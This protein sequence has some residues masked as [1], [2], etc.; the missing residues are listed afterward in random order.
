MS[1]DMD[2][3]ILVGNDFNLNINHDTYITFK[4]TRKHKI[5]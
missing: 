5:R 1:H 3:T 4:K 2:R